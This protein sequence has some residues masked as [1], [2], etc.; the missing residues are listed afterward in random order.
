MKKRLTGATFD[1]SAQTIVHPDFSDITLA[2]IQLITNVTDQ[3]II[4]NFA[5]TTKGG[6]LATDT[7]TLEY[8]T[9]SMSDTDELMILVEDGTTTQAVSATDLDI[10]DL[11]QASDG[12][13]IYGSD[14]GGTTKRII[15]TDAGGAIQVDL[16]VSS[17]S[18]SN[19]PSEY[20]LPAAQVTTLTPQTDALTDTQL[21]ATPVS[22]TDANIADHDDIFGRPTT[23]SP[24]NDIDIQF[25]KAAPGS[26]LTVTTANSATATS[27]VGGALF[28]SSTNTNGSVQGVTTETTTYKSG[29]EVYAMFTASFT[30]GIASSYMRIGLYN[31]NNGF[32]IG[33]EGTTFGVT[34][35]NDASDT[36]VAKASFSE[37]DLTGSA[38]SRFTR[39]G[40][41]E[42]INLTKLNVFRIRFGWLGSAPCFW[43]VMSPDGHWVTFHK[44]LFPNLQT[45][46]SV[47]SA[48]LPITL[49]ITKTGAAATDLQIQTD[50]WGAGTSSGTQE[51]QSDK[52]AFSTTT[53]LAGGATY[54]SGVL[55]LS[56]KYSQVQTQVLASKAGTINIYWYSDAAGTDLVRTITIPYGA[57]DGFQMFS[58]PAFTPY[59]KYEYVNDPGAA[60]TDFYFDTKFLRRPLSP[61]ILRVDGTIVGG[62]VST[63]NRSVIAGESS[64]GGGG[65]YVNVKVNPSGTLETNATVSG[66]V[67]A[68]LSD[69]D[70]AVLDAIEADTTT[71]AG[72]VS[73]TEMQVDVVTSA[74]PTGAA[75]AANQQTDALTDDELRATPVPVSGTV[76]L[77]VTD[78]AVLD[79]IAASVAGATPAGTNNI[80]DVD[81]LTLPALPVGTNV[82]GKVSVDQATPGTTNFVQNKEMPDA[83]STFSPTNATTTAYAASLVVKA[84]AGTL[85]SITGY[86]SKASAQFIQVHNT[87][88]LPADT[89]VPIVI[90]TVPAASNFSFSADKFGRF[91]STGITICNSSTGPTKTIGSA[92]CWFDVQYN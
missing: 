84:S 23:T 37:D 28:A 68:N 31:A 18:V 15:K 57:S 19:L 29:S 50:C 46:P 61:Q 25:F 8:D 6:T 42:A 54:S 32:F 86:N 71:L 2:G 63:L 78:N 26:L 77:G 90:F 10:R 7:L 89:A 70:N 87:A 65:G 79:A 55:A 21:R 3:V 82:I 83:T 1:A 62:M 22:V 36:T 73:G 34:V 9:T 80:G 4:Y 38:T 33:Y 60:Q 27:N 69:T 5:D 35:R 43:E 52:I 11:T 72:A 64:S 81:V 13:A 56:P 17:V 39:D 14:D 41:P 76:D 40:T 51:A 59:V 44:T 12:V 74:L 48:D 49:D 20:P 66:T 58:A 92:D 47:R 24:N 88:S 75:T 85:Y 67:T 16:E 53:V 30:A 45:T 91:F